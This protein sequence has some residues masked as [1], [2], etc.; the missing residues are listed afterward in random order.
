MTTPPKKPY[1]E[2]GLL[3]F[4]RRFPDEKACWDYLILTR[5]PLGITC[6][7][8]KSKKSDFIR[9]RKVFECKR[10]HRHVSVI[11]GT[12]FDKTRL[13]LRKWF[14]ALF[15]MS[16]SKKG[17]SMLY[18]QNQLKIKS[19]RTAWLMGQ[20]IRQAMTQREALYSLKENTV[21]ADEIII[22]GRRTYE[23]WKKSG[24]NKSNFLIMVEED[25]KSRPGFVSFE[26]LETIYEKHLLPALKKKVKK[27][28]SVKT[29]GFNVYRNACKQGYYRHKSY[30][31]ASQKEESEEN[32]K[33]VNMLTSNLKRF[34]LSTY[35]G[36]RRKY[37]KAYLAEFAYRFNRRHWPGQAFDRLLFACICSKPAPL[38]VLS[39]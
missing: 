20:K 13:P 34:L 36:V 1:K 35:H 27:G 29:D 5:W 30:A 2:M 24:P 7:G 25:K 10:C 19:Y 17:V 21:Q 38:P 26:K 8:C 32:L 18:L 3:D 22:G 37:H 14:W 23:E 16:T 28:A 6:F 4:D 31:H 11:A 39:A 33:W 9:T 15:L 12:I